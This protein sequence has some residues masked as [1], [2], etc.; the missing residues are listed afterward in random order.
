MRPCGDV[1]ETLGRR[2]AHPS[3][4]DPVPAHIR[5]LGSVSAKPTRMAGGRGL[6]RKT[7][8][9]EARAQARAAQTQG[10]AHHVWV[11]YSQPHVKMSDVR[12]RGL[13]RNTTWLAAASHHG[14]NASL[15]D[16]SAQR[17]AGPSARETRAQGL[18]HRNRKVLESAREARRA[19]GGLPSPKAGL[20][21]PA[22][23]AWRL[24]TR[25]RRLT[26]G[27]KRSAAR[28]PRLASGPSRPV[29]RR[30]SAALASA[31]VEPRTRRATRGALLRARQAPTLAPT[32][33]GF[34]VGAA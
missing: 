12:H 27:T 2:T 18:A 32:A 13:D 3:H 1:N 19:G 29:S 21:E 31:R 7:G 9:V 6:R 15:A 5:S 22:V 8:A 10:F 20:R 26:A 33:P 25:V 4:R 17:K 30:P 14:P 23:R 34:G 16:A 24:T 28:V 11:G